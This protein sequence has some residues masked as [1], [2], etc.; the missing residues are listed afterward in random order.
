MESR[1]L[2]SPGM[3]QVWRKWTRRFSIVF[4]P[5]VFF[6][7]WREKKSAK[8]Y[9]AVESTVRSGPAMFLHLKSAAASFFSSA[10]KISLT[11][12]TD[13]WEYLAQNCTPRRK[14]LT[15]HRETKQTSRES[16][17]KK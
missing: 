9:L 17:P 10:V 13:P 1:N 7:S 4:L 3:Q 11:V 8:V 15:R 14:V 5:S 2:L 6:I 16:K 12:T